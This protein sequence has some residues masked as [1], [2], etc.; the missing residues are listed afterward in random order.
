MSFLFL[1]GYLNN[2]M[3][4]YVYRI[5]EDIGNKFSEK[6]VEKIAGILALVGFA[7]G[8]V[9]GRIAKPRSFSSH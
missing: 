8:S 1:Y 4:I 2:E 7:L 9:V 6:C 5:F 3:R